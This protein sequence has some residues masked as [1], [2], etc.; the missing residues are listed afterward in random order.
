MHLKHNK[1]W[2]SKFFFLKKKHRRK[3]CVRMILSSSTQD[4]DPI[5][6][7]NV[8][9]PHV[10]WRFQWWISKTRTGNKDRIALP[11]KYRVCAWRSYWRRRRGRQCVSLR[12]KSP[13]KWKW[14]NCQRI[15]S[16]TLRLMREWHALLRISN[17]PLAW[18]NIIFNQIT[19]NETRS[20]L[21]MV[22]EI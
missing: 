15:M 9:N 6:P 17:S 21:I 16:K 7:W 11:P 4:K 13:T 20:N 1:W 14:T 12:P 22:A 2:E 3:M 8:G 18:Y 10:Y 19:L 5:K